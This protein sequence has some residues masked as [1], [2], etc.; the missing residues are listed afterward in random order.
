MFDSLST[1]IR[2]S[3]SQN[4]VRIAPQQTR[5]IS[6]EV[7]QLSQ[8]STRQLLVQLHL[9]QYS[10]EHATASSTLQVSIPLRSRPEFWKPES[11]SLSAAQ[12]AFV[13]T[14][15]NQDGVV[16]YASVVPP[17]VAWAGVNKEIQPPV[18]LA[19]HGAGVLTEDEFWSS[20]LQ[21]QDTSWIVMPSGRTSW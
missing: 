18:I 14:Q 13:I 4:S 11:R 5:L 3:L 21:R 15:L 12:S 8:L 19:L 6:L 9:K 1:Q 2:T 7:L 17:R 16:D 20:A 10:D